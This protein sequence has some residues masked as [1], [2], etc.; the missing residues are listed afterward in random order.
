MVVVVV[1]VVVTRSVAVWWRRCGGECGD[2]EC[3]R[4]R[5]GVA[6]ESSWCAAR[7][8]REAGAAEGEALQRRG[9]LGWG[10][11]G[12]GEAGS[13][14]TQGKQ[15]QLE[16]R[17]GETDGEEREREREREIVCVCVCVCER[18]RERELW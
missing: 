13:G 8:S 15:Q 11:M 10:A 17:Y 5:K 1:V 7:S 14:I 16:E 18:E 2:I 6:Q 4:S 9:W 3:L 12:V